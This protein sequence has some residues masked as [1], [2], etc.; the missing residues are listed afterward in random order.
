MKPVV[1]FILMLLCIS[2]NA[3]V[4]AGSCVAVHGYGC[5]GNNAKCCRDGD[6]YTGTMRRCVNVGKSVDEL[7]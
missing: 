3:Y 6:P 1:I 7:L 4:E 5:E 2:Q